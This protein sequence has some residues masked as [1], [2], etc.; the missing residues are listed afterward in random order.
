MINFVMLTW[1][2]GNMSYVALVRLLIK[3]WHEILFGTGSLNLGTGWWRVLVLPLQ[4]LYPWGSSAVLI[5]CIC[6][7]A[8][9]DKEAQKKN[10]CP[11]CDSCMSHP[12]QKLS[13][14]WQFVQHFIE[15]KL[16]KLQPEIQKVKYH[17]EDV[18]IGGWI[19]LNSL[20][21]KW[22]NYLLY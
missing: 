16:I 14:C 19:M 18:R 22:S 20:S 6:L 5:A 2:C 9:R 7:A 10:S 21:K 1:C 3:R 4:S 12:A 15:Q 11:C 17:L 13:L 8:G